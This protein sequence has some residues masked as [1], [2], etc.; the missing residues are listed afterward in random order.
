MFIAEDSPLYQHK[1]AYYN[2]FLALKTEYQT[3]KDEDPDAS[4]RREDISTKL[5]ELRGKL[6]V[7]EDFLDDFNKRTLSFQDIDKSVYES[8]IGELVLSSENQV[9]IKH[10]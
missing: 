5:V 10:K 6:Q 3:V 8:L 7:L 4:V 2:E 1:N 9:D